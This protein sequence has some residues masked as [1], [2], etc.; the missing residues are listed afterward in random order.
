MGNTMLEEFMKLKLRLPKDNESLLI[1]KLTD[2]AG[3]SVDLTNLKVLEMEDGHMGSL[4]LFTDGEYVKRKST[5]FVS[6]IQFKDEDGI[7]VLATLY[8]DINGI[9]SE[10]DIWKTNF[11]PLIKIPCSFNE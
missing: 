1:Q 3:K 10:L 4:L 6:E 2:K 5:N 11:E 9:I 7:M 8:S